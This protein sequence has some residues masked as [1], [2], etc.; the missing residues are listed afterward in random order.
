MRRA[1][2]AIHRAHLRGLRLP[3]DLDSLDHLH[4]HQCKPAPAS[5]EK[6]AFDYKNKSKGGPTAAV[7]MWTMQNAVVQQ[8]EDS[9]SVDSG[10]LKTM[11]SDGPRFDN[12]YHG[13]GEP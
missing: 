9:S 5:K 6:N 11:L 10:Y 12:G 1:F 7:S 2:Q 8:V 4:G 13:H 3:D